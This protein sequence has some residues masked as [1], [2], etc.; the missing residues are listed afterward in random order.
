[1]TDRGIFHIGPPPMP[2]HRR[3]GWW[4]AI[5]FKTQSKSHGG[6][7]SI[8]KPPWGPPP[9]GRGSEALLM[10]PPTKILG[11]GRIKSRPPWGGI[12]ERLSRTHWAPDQSL[13]GGIGGPRPQGGRG[14]RALVSWGGP[15]PMVGWGLMILI[16]FILIL[17]LKIC[18]LVIPN[19][20]IKLLILITFLD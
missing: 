14:G 11:R 9:H 19:M 1:M 18:L 4:G 5:I 8:P 17:C 7:K 3:W 6:P 2:P 12:L 13:I 16:R 20:L 15:P 10:A